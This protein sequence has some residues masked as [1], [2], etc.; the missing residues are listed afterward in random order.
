MSWSTGLD[1]FED[2]RGVESSSA[3][4]NGYYGVALLGKAIGYSSIYDT[5]RLLLATEIRSSKKYF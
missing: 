5:A 2:N 4:I 1:E 3:S